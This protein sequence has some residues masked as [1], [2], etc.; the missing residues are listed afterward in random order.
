MALEAVND[1]MMKVFKALPDYK[2]NQGSFF[3]WV[4]TIVRNAAVDKL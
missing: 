1:G 2:Y 4:Y 3:N